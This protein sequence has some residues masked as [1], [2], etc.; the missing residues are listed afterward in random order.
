MNYTWDMFRAQNGCP[1]IVTI[2]LTYI[3]LVNEIYRSVYLRERNLFTS[4]QFRQ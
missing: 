2:K 1:A 3:A 4:F